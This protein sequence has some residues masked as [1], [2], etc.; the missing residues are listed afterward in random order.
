MVTTAFAKLRAISRRSVSRRD[1]SLHGDC[2]FVVE[3]VF[4][5][6][7]I[8]SLLGRLYPCSFTAFLQLTFILMVIFMVSLLPPSIFKNDCTILLLLSKSQACYI[9]QTSHQSNDKE[10]GKTG[11]IC[12]IVLI[13]F[14]K[15][16]LLSLF[17]TPIFLGHTDTVEISHDPHR[18]LPRSIRH[19]EIHSFW[20]GRSLRDLG[21]EC[22]PGII[23][24]HAIEREVITQ[25]R[26]SWRL[27]TFTSR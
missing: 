24:G 26:P 19:R 17:I 6:I 12:I 3:L 10:K 27:V 8:N 23:T 21:L 11:W 4:V 13:I 5:D 25:K 7:I 16:S 14:F 9:I 2:R 22:F 1:I 20:I 15:I 18:N